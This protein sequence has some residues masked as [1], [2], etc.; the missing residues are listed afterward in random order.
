M[1]TSILSIEI[2]QEKKP[3]GY[4]TMGLKPLLRWFVSKIGTNTVTPVW[5]Y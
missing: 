3:H 1:V 5:Q 2:L 4:E